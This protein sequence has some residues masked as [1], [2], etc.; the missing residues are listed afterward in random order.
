MIFINDCKKLS[1]VIYK[2]G[3]TELITDDNKCSLD[4]YQVTSFLMQLD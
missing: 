3:W 2:Y 4:S 1:N